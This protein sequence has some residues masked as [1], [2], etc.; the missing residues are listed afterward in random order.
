MREYSVPCMCVCGLLTLIYLSLRL[1]PSYLPTSL[2][3]Y[4]PNTSPL[5]YLLF[6]HQPSRGESHNSVGRLRI[7]PLHRGSSEEQHLREV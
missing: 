2:L 7:L 1:L 3:F 4:F 5:P 6:S